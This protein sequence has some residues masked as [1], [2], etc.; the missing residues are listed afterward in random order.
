MSWR[1]GASAPVPGVKLS[2]DRGEKGAENSLKGV[3]Q[4]YF[5]ETGF[6]EAR[7]YDRYALQPGDALQGPAVVEERESTTVIGP[8]ATVSVDAYL[9]LICELPS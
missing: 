1:L 3:R 2:F 5:P 6:T 8:G 4:A 7:V 9:N